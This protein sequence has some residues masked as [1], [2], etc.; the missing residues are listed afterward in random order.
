LTGLVPASHELAY[1]AGREQRKLSLD[2][3]PAPAL[4]VSVNSDRNVGTL[5]IISNEAGFEVR[6]NGRPARFALQRG[7]YLIYNLDAKE[8]TVEISKAGFDVE[9]P[10]QAITIRKG[11]ITPATFKLTPTP[12]TATL[13]I[14]GALPGTRLSLNGTAHELQPNGGLELTIPPG[15]HRIEFTRPGFKPKSRQF[16]AQAG[17]TITL[18]GNDVLVNEGTT[19]RLTI[20]SRVP[21]NSR[22]MLRQGGLEVPITGREAEVPE[23][24]YTLIAS[25]EGFRDFSRAVRI[26]N[27]SPA[28]MD[29]Q[30]ARIPQ[31]VR[32]EGWDNPGGWK[33]ENGW[34]NRK[35]GNF[36]LFKPSSPA[37]T[38]QFTARHRGRQFP[39][40][41]GGRIRWVINYADASNYELYELDGQRL[42]WRRFAGGQPGAEKQAPHGV[43]I[44]ND[45]YRL[46]LDIGTGQGPGKIFDGTT[47]KPLPALAEP[48]EGRFGFYLP[49]EEEMW[50]ID[51]SFNPT[52]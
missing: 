34:Y 47:W 40:F 27:G 11:L 30:L 52:E 35:G 48:G 43:R 20:T 5:Q 16:S 19:G 41:R 25:A 4:F 36:A 14:H 39:A 3:S 46:V 8:T 13:L 42:Y 23:G 26:A 33:L 24:D 29:I 2:I 37:G 12:T 45:T 9:P 22:V 7:R 10:S 31:V 38:V 1:G 28:V 51:F 6:I 21:P 49:N 50:L 18:A 17:Q 32:M 15:T 44:Q